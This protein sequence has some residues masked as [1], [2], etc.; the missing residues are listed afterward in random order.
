MDEVPT[1]PNF[2]DKRSPCQ[3]IYAFVYLSKTA[4]EKHDGIMPHWRPQ[5]QV[6]H[7]RVCQYQRPYE[8]PKHSRKVH[9]SFNNRAESCRAISGK[10]TRNG[11]GSRLA[12]PKCYGNGYARNRSGFLFRKYGHYTR[13]DQ[14]CSQCWHELD[15]L[16][17]RRVLSSGYN[18]HS[19][20][21]TRF[22]HTPAH[23]RWDKLPG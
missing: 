9:G 2:G 19:L 10:Q 13:R 18:Q 1:I 4:G 3:G 21:S 8:E 15:R 14:R 22:G 11:D 20:Y 17:K 12:G 16:R 7:G 6:T 23:G 5:A